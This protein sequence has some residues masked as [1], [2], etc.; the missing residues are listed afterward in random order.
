VFAAS[1]NPDPDDAVRK[2]LEELA[3]TR[4]YSE[5]VLRWMP[6]PS[7]DEDYAEVATQAQ[8][9][10]LAADPSSAEAF[11]FLFAASERIDFDDLV[12]RSTGTAAG[13]LEVV[14]EGIAQTGLRTYVADL[15]SPDI[16]RLGLTVTRTIVPGLHPLFMG[17]GL[18]ARGGARLRKLLEAAGRNEDNPYPHP[19]P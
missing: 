11:R 18:R 7:S 9:L 6:C 19:Y 2:A 14:C 10:R 13:D 8:H 17:H 12:D 16:R 3:H 4:R 1:A 15:T 5:Q